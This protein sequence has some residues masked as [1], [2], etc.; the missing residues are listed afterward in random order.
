MANP[1][2]F[3]AGQVLTAAQMNGIGEA[4]ASYTPTSSGITVGNG[5]LT[6]TFTRVNKL[7]Y[8]AVKFALGSTS[9]ITTTVTFS[10]PV[11]ASTNS[12]GLLIGIGY[13]FDN[14]ASETYLG[15]S[16]RS[17]TTTLTPFVAFAGNPYL[18]RSIVNATVPVVFGAG[19]EMVYQFLYE[20][21]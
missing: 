18:V 17:N 10:L 3:T 15:T 8:G 9:A 1:F 4:T 11:T 13:Y 6:G 7:V 14:S 20:A 21:A 2:P 16:F 12:A 19:D 5:S